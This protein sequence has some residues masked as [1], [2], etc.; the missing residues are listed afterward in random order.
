MTIW[1][2]TVPQP[3]QVHAVE[4]EDTE[5]SQ[6]PAPRA[7]HWEGE[8]SVSFDVTRNGQ[9][10]NL[11]ITVPFGLS[12][13]TVTMG[14]TFIGQQN[15]ITMGEPTGEPLAGT[16]KATLFITGQFT[17]ETILAGT[18]RIG[19]CHT[20]GDK[21]TAIAPPH[22]GAWNA[23]WKSASD[24]SA[25]TTGPTPT[26][27][28]VATATPAPTPPSRQSWLPFRSPAPWRRIWPTSGS[29]A[30]AGHP[31]AASSCS[32]GR[33]PARN[34]VR[35][36]SNPARSCAATSPVS[37]TWLYGDF[38][39][40]GSMSITTIQPKPYFS[41]ELRGRRLTLP[42]RTASTSTRTTPAREQLHPGR[43]G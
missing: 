42:M 18:Y 10:H 2:P 27:A 17:G 30:Q 20:T 40:G 21:Y 6:I 15:E 41:P 22:E 43:H 8:P 11:E 25:S 38:W 24:P 14:E 9:V 35:S 13:C 29:G 5:Q 37:R 28:P 12:T 16:F 33:P 1:T 32:C 39:A 36:R 19:I 26:S 23:E 3:W 34:R 7:G 31:A 4:S